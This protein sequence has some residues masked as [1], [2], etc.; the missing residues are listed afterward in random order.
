MSAGAATAQ[1]PAGLAD[2]VHDA[3]RIFRRALSAFAHP[4]RIERLSTDLAPPAPLFATTAGLCLALADQDTPIWL[5]AACDTA[6]VRDYL[7]FH[8]GAPI[9]ADA[10]NSR[11][12]LV[13]EA[14]AMPALADLALGEP[15]YPERSTTLIMQVAGFSANGPYRLSGPGIDGSARLGI[16]G[17]P[18]HMVAFWAENNALFPCGIDLVLASPDAIVALPRTTKMES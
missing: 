3:Q 9:T 5:D 16:A 12:A 8:C 14:M 6:S 17:A 7:R 4:G 2:P 1:M 13:S 15:A 11:F 10:A 18:A